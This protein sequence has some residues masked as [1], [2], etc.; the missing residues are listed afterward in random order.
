MIRVL[1][2]G[3]SITDGVRD[4]Q[5]PEHLG[6]GYAKFVAGTL[7]FEQPGTYEFINRGIAGNRIVDVY[8]RIKKD[9]IN[10]KPDVMSLLVGV[11]D[12][13]QEYTRQNGVDA[14]KYEMIYELLLSEIREALPDMKIIILGSY[15]ENGAR[16]IEE[17]F[18]Y[19]AL[20]KGVE[21][22]AAIAKKM[23]E[24]YGY[25]FVDLQ[26]RFDEAVQRGPMEK[27]TVDGIHPVTGGIEL[28]KRAWL[29]AFEQLGLN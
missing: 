11:N 25:P 21:Q 4:R 22:R 24:K 29:E 10:L 15:V 19:T 5:N 20:R 16:I 9:I 2:Q 8:A 17:G 18:D 12:V 28:I 1:F 6:A 27:F 14:Q 3:D 7:D 26:A 13:W 23:A